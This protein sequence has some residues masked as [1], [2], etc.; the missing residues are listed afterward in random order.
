MWVSL[1]AM[2]WIRELVS[3]SLLPRRAAEALQA[4]RITSRSQAVT[5]LRR[6]TA[7]E[8]ATTSRPAAFHLA[9][10]GEF[11]CYMQPLR[12][13]FAGLSSWPSVWV[14]QVIPAVPAAPLQ[15]PAV[16]SCP[17]SVFLECSFVGAVLHN[18]DAKHC[19]EGDINCIRCVDRGVP[20]CL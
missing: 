11:S 3:D 2:R 1:H 9:A 18:L 7:G 4:R 14:P 20:L 8:S 10:Q 15:A 17:D 19:P 5:R 6:C 13:T 16:G 12:S